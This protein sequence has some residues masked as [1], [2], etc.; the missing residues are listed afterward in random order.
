MWLTG[1]GVGVQGACTQEAHLS[2]RQNHSA[3]ARPT[4]CDEKVANRDV[5]GCGWE[6]A[7]AAVSRR[8]P[9]SVYTMGPRNESYA[10]DVVVWD[11]SIVQEA[12]SRRASVCLD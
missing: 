10:Y 6:I 3:R 11:L 5:R 2:H 7:H 12:F 9:I 1:V 8:P 4:C